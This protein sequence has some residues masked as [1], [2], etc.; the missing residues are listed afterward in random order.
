[1]PRRTPWKSRGCLISLLLVLACG[2]DAGEMDAPP[3]T[4]TSVT[5]SSGSSDSETSQ[6]DSSTE[7]QTP[8]DVGGADEG[9]DPAG[10]CGMGGPVD[11]LTQIELGAPDRWY[12]VGAPDTQERLPVVVV[13]HGDEGEPWNSTAILWG[14]WRQAEDLPFIVAVAKCPGCEQW[15]SGSTE[16]LEDRRDYVYEVLDDV[17]ARYNV[18][19]SRIYAVGYS[20][21]SEFLSIWGFK[22]QEVFAAIQWN[23]GG[24]DWAE[25]YAPPPRDDC[26]VKGRM[27][28]A[29]DDFLY[30]G[31]RNLE[32]LMLQNGHEV[33]F[34]DAGCQGHCCITPEGTVGAWEWFQQHTK[35]DGVVTGECASVDELP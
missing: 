1:M 18:D 17:S 20:G 12:L 13:F 14:E 33:E 19:V 10:S 35:C 2:G 27:V 31:A 34:V 6:D 5:A 4:D 22:M 24:N 3:Q 32:D 7:P 16:E 23:C 9:G 11:G 26:S 25:A 30:D 8:V 15:W 28:I 21:G 29:P